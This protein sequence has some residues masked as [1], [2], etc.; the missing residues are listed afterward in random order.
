MKLQAVDKFQSV[1]AR[2]NNSVMFFEKKYGTSEDYFAEREV[3]AL[4]LPSVEMP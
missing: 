2:C 1:V 3:R 4:V